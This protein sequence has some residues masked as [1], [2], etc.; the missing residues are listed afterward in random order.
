MSRNSTHI[1][2]NQIAGTVNQG[3]WLNDCDPCVESAYQ[4][5]NITQWLR[6]RFAVTGGGTAYAGP[7]STGDIANAAV[8]SQWDDAIGSNNAVQATGADQPVWNDADTLIKFNASDNLDLTAVTYANADNFTILLGFVPNT[9]G[10]F[11][12][13]ALWSGSGNDSVTITSSTTIEVKLNNVAQTI[14]G[15]TL[16]PNATHTCEAVNLTLR[17]SY[18]ICQFFAAGVPWGPSFVW[19]GDYKIETI[20]YDGTND[21]DGKVATFMQFDRDL[22]DKEIW[23]LDCYLCGDDTSGEPTSCRIDWDDVDCNGDTDGSLTATMLGATGA[24]TYLWSTGA[25]T[26]TISSLAAGTYTCTMTDS[27]GTPNV[28]T[29]TGYVN[30]PALALACTTTTAQPYYDASNV[31]QPATI[32]VTVAGGWGA[33]LANSNIVWTKDG[34]AYTPAGA[35]YFN[36]STSVAGT[37]AYTVTDVNGCTCTGSV[38]ITIPGDPTL[39]ILC[40]HTAIECHDETAAWGVMFDASTTFNTTATITMTGSVSGAHA[41][42]PITVSSLPASSTNYGSTGNWWLNTVANQR[43]AAGEV[44][45]ITVTDTGSPVRTATCTITTVNPEDIV[46]QDTVTQPTA[47]EGL[48]WSNGALS[49]TATGGTPPFTYS[50]AKTTATT[51]SVSTNVWLNPG[52]GNYTLTAT[53]DNGC[54]KTKNITIT[55]PMDPMVTIDHVATDMDCYGETPCDGQ[56]V[57]TPSNTTSTGYEFTLTVSDGSSIIQT[58]GPLATFP[59]YTLTGLCTG[60]YTYTYIATLVSTGV[61]TTLANNVA[62]SISEPA[63]LAITA[64]TTNDACNGAPGTGAIDT[65]VTGGTAAYT[66]A[67]TASNGGVIPTGQATNADLTALVA[68]SYSVIVTDANGCTVTRGWDIGQPCE[69]DTTLTAAPIECGDDGN[70]VEYVCNWHLMGSTIGLGQAWASGSGWDHERATFQTSAMWGPGSPMELVCWH[71]YTDG[72]NHPDYPNL[73]GSATFIPIQHPDTATCRLQFQPNQ[74]MYQWLTGLTIGETYN[75]SIDV[76]TGTTASATWKMA[77]YS[78]DPAYT[79]TIL[80]SETTVNSTGVSSTTFTATATEHVI[81]VHFEGVAGSGSTGG[82]NQVLN[83]VGYDVNQGNAGSGIVMSSDGKTIVTA[84]NMSQEILTYKM[85]HNSSATYPYTGGSWVEADRQQ[86]KNGNVMLGKRE[87]I[88]MKGDGT[89][90]I[91]GDQF[92]NQQ[93]GRT[94]AMEWTETDAVNCQG[95][96]TQMGANFEGSNSGD[97]AGTVAMSRDGSVIAIGEPGH[98]NDT[99]IVKLYTWNSGTTSWD[100]RGSTLTGGTDGE[101]FGFSIDLSADGAEVVIGAPEHDWQN[102]TTTGIKGTVR[103]YEWNGSAWAQ[104]GADIDGT[105]NERFGYAVSMDSTGAIIAGNS[106]GNLATDFKGKTRIYTYGGS[107]WSQTGADIVGEAINDRSG[108]QISLN[109]D[110]S[111]IVI[112]AAE[113]DPTAITLENA[114]HLRVYKNVSGTWTQQG[115]DIDHTYAYDYYGNDVDISENGLMVVGGMPFYGDNYEGGFMVHELITSS[116]GPTGVGCL[117]YISV[118]GQSLTSNTTDIIVNTTCGTSPYTYAWTTPS[119]T[120]QGALGS[121]AA[122]AVDLIDVVAGTYQV[123]TTDANGCTDTVSLVVPAAGNITNSIVVIANDDCDETRCVGSLASATQFPNI[124]SYL[125]TT[126]AA[127]TTPV[128]GGVGSNQF[129]ITEQCPG[130][131]YLRVT[132]DNGCIWEGSGTITGGASGMSLS[133]VVTDADMCGDCCGEI[134]LTVTG[135]SA[136]FTYIWSNGATTQDLTCVNPGSYTV[137]VTDDAGCIETATYTVGVSNYPITFTLTG[138]PTSQEIIVGPVSGGT[139]P[140]SYQWTLNGTNYAAGTTSTATIPNLPVT[141]NGMYCLIVNDDLGCR[142]EVC[143]GV[144]FA[145]RETEEW[146]CIAPPQSCTMTKLKEDLLGDC[147]GENQ[148]SVHEMSG[149]GTTLVV[150]SPS[151]NTSMCE[152][153]QGQRNPNTSLTANNAGRVKVFTINAGGSYTQIG[154]DLQGNNDDE[155]FGTSVAVSNDGN[156]VVVGAP[157][158]AQNSGAVYVYEYSSALDYWIGTTALAHAEDQE[159]WGSDVSISADGTRLIGVAKKHEVGGKNLGAVRAYDLSASTW[160]QK[161]ADIDGQTVGTGTGVDGNWIESAKISNDGTTIAVG[162]VEGDSTNES[163]VAVYRFSSSAWNQIGSDIATTSAANMQSAGA[164]LSLSTDG[165]IVAVGVPYHQVNPSTFDIEGKIQV[166][167]YGGSAWTQKGS[168]IIGTHD[169]DAFGLKN[170][171]WLSGDGLTLIVGAPSSAHG[172]QINGGKF[173]LY[174]FITSTWSQVCD[175]HYGGGGKQQLGKSVCINTAGT[176][177]SVGNG[178][179]SSGAQQGTA[180]GK[181]QVY[182]ITYS[183]GGGSTRCTPCYTIGCGSYNTLASCLSACTPS[184]SFNCTDGRCVDPGDGTG[185]YATEALCLESGCQQLRTMYDCKKG[186]GCVGSVGIGTYA[187]LA[188]CEAACTTPSEVTYYCEILC[189]DSNDAERYTDER[190][191]YD[192]DGETEERRERETQTG[193][194]RCR[195]RKDTSPETGSTVYYATEKLCREACPWCKDATKYEDIS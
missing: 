77:V 22:T 102:A 177:I 178:S 70:G 39:S 155:F 17:R 145:T 62:F 56:V 60:S 159:E 187:T 193:G 99:G 151:W 117:Q 191:E 3:I 53:D 113:N 54:V 118:T 7:I 66:Y 94:I 150:A 180:I 26:Q 23:C 137:Q 65:T 100:Q 20:G 78:I 141:Q 89:R 109:G 45:T 157:G 123:V 4:I 162:I 24:V 9:A 182:D 72:V 122:T 128:T 25:T 87:N 188:A 12:T 104:K 49:F 130:T 36:I 68:G 73:L 115:S 131:Y 170:T 183:A 120:P 21:L 110:G 136:P 175:V 176:R 6:H 107:S 105:S 95:Y 139:P 55:C 31:L 71:G 168:D 125:W 158:V 67:W 57:F 135:G 181:V 13:H 169:Q 119:A 19:T 121:N 63:P 75:F 10:T 129:N 154:Q 69:L 195:I 153:I 161:G 92:W 64:V 80:G 103:V 116:N 5:P 18:G 111:Y 189:P 52:A 126:D 41:Q 40:G 134:D 165:S 2:C 144:D 46:I 166:F 174:K 48:D 173:E 43:L 30:E 140:Y 76:G 138:S 79:L 47:C 179:W 8:I 88:A 32:S 59:A 163:K 127:Y 112:G 98:T 14:T 33:P 147:P 86:Y 93:Q 81:N 15:P 106:Q 167:E 160:T 124:Q 85:C 171:I 83:T 149:D 132:L 38:V 146:N 16:T 27:A 58:V 51:G 34:S 190:E 143:I 35:D 114:G 42:S 152:G 192:H 50:I 133:A 11:S 172:G 1:N 91:I 148:G 96:W 142:E 90:M 28:T 82:W 108:N 61:I 29:C 37:Y 74:G 194:G 97:L 185:T 164:S 101:K 184:A 84:S 156:T 186:I 44:W